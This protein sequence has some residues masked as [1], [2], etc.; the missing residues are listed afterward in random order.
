MVADISVVPWYPVTGEEEG[1]ALVD[2]AI[3]VIQASGLRT[4]TLF[5]LAAG[6]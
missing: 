4:D 1:Y 2:E 6:E 5:Y 3:K